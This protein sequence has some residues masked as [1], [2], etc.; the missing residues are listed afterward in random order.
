VVYGRGADARDHRVTRLATCGEADR[1]VMAPTPRKPPLGPERRSA[2]GILADAPR[3][4]TEAMLTTHG[5]TG[6]LIA[7]LVRDG[8]AT[9]QA[10]S[11]QAGGQRVEVRRVRIT[12]AGRRAVET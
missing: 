11:V 9:V 3:G 4:L 6:K 7:G 2:L 10:E 8:L 12:D 1:S 5:V